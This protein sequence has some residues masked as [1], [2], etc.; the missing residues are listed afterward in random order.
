MKLSRY[1]QLLASFAR[2]LSA[3]PAFERKNGTPV[4]CF[5]EV[6]R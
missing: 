2:V 4:S 6:S 3:Q 1:V 5:Q